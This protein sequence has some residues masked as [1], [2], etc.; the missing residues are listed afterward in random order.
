LRES[1][2]ARRAWYGCVLPLALLVS[3]AYGEG[4]E[5]AFELVRAV[6]EELGQGTSIRAEYDVTYTS[7]GA[8]APIKYQVKYIRDG[9]KFNILAQGRQA[10]SDTVWTEHRVCDGKSVVNFNG[11]SGA[12]AGSALIVPVGYGYDEGD[13]ALTRIMVDSQMGAD[14]RE[15]NP[16]AV[17]T[18]VGNEDIGGRTCAKVLLKS[19]YT[20]GHPAYTYFWIDT[21]G[22]QPRLLKTLCLKDN[23]PAKMV[24]GISY[25]YDTG[26]AST[27]PTRIVRDDGEREGGFWQV[28]IRATRK[29][30]SIGKV[31][32]S[33]AIADSEFEFQFTKG[34]QVQDRVRNINYE[35]G[36]KVYSVNDIAVDELKPSVTVD[37]EAEESDAAGGEGGA[38]G[39]AASD[40]A[41]AAQGTPVVPVGGA[42]AGMAEKKGNGRLLLGLVIAVVVV[43][44]VMKGMR[45]RKSGG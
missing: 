45:T 39:I 26:G 12:D 35:V 43:A 32:L 20:E 40:S 34:M 33:A 28:T 18:L 4:D 13:Q 5:R 6:S 29:E 30:V 23:D 27:F 31:E 16:Q 3:F 10:N 9:N 14:Y 42:E 7:E 44:A 19:P 24:F 2:N 38:E 37:M 36:G 1:V 25:E 41:A 22:E 11:Q 17:F 15:R 8:P 21:S